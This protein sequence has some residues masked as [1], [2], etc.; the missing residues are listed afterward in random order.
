M[1]EIS[2]KEKFLFEWKGRSKGMI[3]NYGEKDDFSDEIKKSWLK[4]AMMIA[5]QYYDRLAKWQKD[6]LIEFKQ[7][8]DSK[9][10]TLGDAM[11]EMVRSI[12]RKEM[13]MPNYVI[14]VYPKVNW[15]DEDLKA[16]ITC[17]D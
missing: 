4:G 15:K 9:T 1:K 5:D 3:D 8:D 7:Y 14:K 2:K 6:L 10:Y 11:Q 12:V 13:D 16:W 17:W